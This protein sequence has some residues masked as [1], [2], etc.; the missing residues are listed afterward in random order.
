MCSTCE[1]QTL[2]CTHAYIHHNCILYIRMHTTLH[3]VLNMYTIYPY[4]LE[5]IVLGYTQCR[6]AL[7][8]EFRLPIF[9]VPLCINK[10]KKNRKTNL[11]SGTQFF[12]PPKIDPPPL[13]AEKKYSQIQALLYSK[14]P[15]WQHRSNKAIGKLIRVCGAEISSETCVKQPNQTKPSIFGTSRRISQPHILGLI[16]RL[17][18]WNPVAKPVVLNTIKPT[19]ENISFK[20]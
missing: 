1:Q 16:Y 2:T 20:A 12:L 11:S 18:C 17:L 5:C 7:S 10:P 19:F 14:R 6:G 8:L 4:T 3:N 9:L 13:K 15:A